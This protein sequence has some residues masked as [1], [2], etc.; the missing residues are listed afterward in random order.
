MA[1]AAARRW[2]AGLGRWGMLVVVGDV[3]GEGGGG[4]RRQISR[5]PAMWAAPEPYGTSYGDGT[6]DNTASMRAGTQSD[7]ADPEC[8]GGGRHNRTGPAAGRGGERRQLEAPEAPGWQARR[9]MVPTPPGFVPE[10]RQTAEMDARR[11]WSMGLFRRPSSLT[12]ARLMVESRNI[13]LSM[14]GKIGKA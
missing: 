5:G 14:G 8:R 7:G 1:C 4:E 13:P 9:R 11:R 12:S 10:A 6:P 2:G 3:A